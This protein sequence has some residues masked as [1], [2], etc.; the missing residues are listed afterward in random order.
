M[1]PTVTWSPAVLALC[2]RSPTAI[3]YKFIANCAWTL[4]WIGHDSGDYLLEDNEKAVITVWLADYQYDAV[5]GLYY[6]LG[7]ADPFFTD[8]D[9]T[10]NYVVDENHTFTLEVKTQQDA[11]LTIER[12]TPSYLDAVIDLR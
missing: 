12:T 6:V 5:E 3:Q 1:P 8:T 4:D 7:A 11:T 2:P 9:D 10:N